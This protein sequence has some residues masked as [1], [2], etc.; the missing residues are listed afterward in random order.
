MD[1]NF[2]WDRRKKLCETLLN[3]DFLV[4][5]L[6]ILYLLLR[7]RLQQLLLFLDDLRQIFYNLS[8]LGRSLILLGHFH[9]E[10]EGR[11]FG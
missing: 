6:V 7:L 5:H 1:Q 4:I 8:F 9:R 10:G 11:A 2:G 3:L